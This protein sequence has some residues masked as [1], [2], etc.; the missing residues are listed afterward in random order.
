MLVSIIIPTHNRSQ[1][2]LLTLDSFIKQNFNKDNFEIIVADNNSS[3]GTADIVQSFINE[4]TEHKI[5]YF[6]ESRQGAHFARNAASKKAIGEFL[7]FADDDMIADPNLLNELLFLFSLDSKVASVTGL[8]LPKWEVEPP[9]WILKLCNN[10]WLSL[11]NPDYDLIISNYDCN[12]FSCHQMI[13]RDVFFLSGGFN[14]DNTMGEWIGDGETGL[15]IKIKEMGFKFGFNRR[16]VIYHII[17]ATRLTQK[18][19]NKRLSNQGNCDTYTLYRKYKS[20]SG[21]LFFDSF[22]SFLRILYSLLLFS[23]RI[24]KR[25]IRWR[26]S[27]AYSYYYLARIKYNWKLMND[28]EW[29]KLVLKTNWIDE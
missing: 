15:N 28:K 18:Y 22:L 14:P 6:L 7:Y 16:S 10:G 20:S 29:T 17:P 5:T 26:L 12:V 23:F 2:I 1:F 9:D 21:A 11:N 4:H 8:V 27:F 24:I 19:L 25:D 3:D 13:K